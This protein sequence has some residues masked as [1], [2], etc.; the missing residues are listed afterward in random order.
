MACTANAS[1]ALTLLAPGVSP[2]N[3]GR[4][5]NVLGWIDGTHIA[6]DIDSSTMGILS[7]DAGAVVTIALTGADKMQMA[8]IMPGAL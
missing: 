2:H 1:Q 8:A 5:Y 3:L 4:R 7:A 6:V